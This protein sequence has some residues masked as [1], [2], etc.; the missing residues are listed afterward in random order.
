MSGL[1]EISKLPGKRKEVLCGEKMHGGSECSL[2][3][4]RK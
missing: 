4:S 1:K 2:L 3:D